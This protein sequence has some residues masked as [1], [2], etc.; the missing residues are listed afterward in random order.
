MVASNLNTEQLPSLKRNSRP[1]SPL[2]NSFIIHI[3]AYSS[4][5]FFLPIVLDS[6]FVYVFTNTTRVDSSIQTL[7]RVH[8]RKV[9][10]AVSDL[11]SWNEKLSRGAWGLNA[12]LPTELDRDWGAVPERD[13]QWGRWLTL[14]VVGPGS[15]VFK[16][17]AR[18]RFSKECL[19]VN[20]N[21]ISAIA[22]Y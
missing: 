7:L 16:L 20:S 9:T 22:L 15:L 12:A 5:V 3:C 1:T 14:K 4:R 18:P 6:T 21:Y 10:C 8:D 13:N 11:S 19:R 17:V 2:G